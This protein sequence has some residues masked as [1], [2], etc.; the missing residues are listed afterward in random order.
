MNCL[1]IGSD[2][3]EHIQQSIAGYWIFTDDMNFDTG[4]PKA[5]LKSVDPGDFL[6]L[7]SSNNVKSA[8]P[9]LT[10]KWAPIWHFADKGEIR[11]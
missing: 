10:G 5:K 3:E 11:V 8:A 7:T 9:T 2:L 4:N 6:Y 1:F